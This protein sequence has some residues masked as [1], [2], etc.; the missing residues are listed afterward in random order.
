MN[1]L[2][3]K[4]WKMVQH[5]QYQTYLFHFSMGCTK[6]NCICWH[7]GINHFSSVTKG[8]SR[9]FC[10]NSTTSKGY[11]VYVPSTRKIISSHDVVF[12]QTFLVHSHT[13][14]VHIHITHS[15]TGSIICSIR[16]IISKTNWWHYNFC[17]NLRGRFSGKWT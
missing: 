15:A 3:H 17:K 1:Q 12:V 4:N 11:L 10:W 14:H 9:Y 7:K 2:Y 5:L 13:C 16:Y 6:V 8:C